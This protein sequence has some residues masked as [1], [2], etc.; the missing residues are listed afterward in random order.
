MMA[1][2]EDLLATLSVGGAVATGI[3]LVAARKWRLKVLALAIQYL[4]VVLLL[5]RTIRVELA[6]VKGL[7]GWLICAVFY[8]TERRVGRSEAPISPSS[9]RSGTRWYRGFLSAKG[10]FH[11]VAALLVSTVAYGAA[12]HLPLSELPAETTLACYL[13]AGLGLLLVGLND[14]PFDV[15]LGLLTTLTGVD[16]VY[17][18]LEPSLA[19]AGLVGAVGFLVALATAYLR[20]AQAQAAGEGRTA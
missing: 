4:V 6:A 20:S 7:T 19:V 16:L 8:V 10:W 2:I 3:T 11:L 9:T 12:L 1:E 15:G 14:N 13:L 5:T 17:V 18:S